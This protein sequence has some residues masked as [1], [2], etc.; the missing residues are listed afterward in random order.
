V[1]RGNLH[2]RCR[3]VLRVEAFCRDVW[4]LRALPLVGI[5]AGQQIA[6]RGSAEPA[7]A[8]SEVNAVTSGY[9]QVTS[10]FWTAVVIGGMELLIV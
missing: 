6:A 10:G 9:A 7:K 4:W 1:Q 2:S 3:S 8:A 5:C